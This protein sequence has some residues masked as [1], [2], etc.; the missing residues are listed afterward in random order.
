MV[1]SSAAAAA[2]DRTGDYSTGRMVM[3]GGQIRFVPTAYLR[4]NN[5]P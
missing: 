4:R 3:T 1:L 5:R 2:L